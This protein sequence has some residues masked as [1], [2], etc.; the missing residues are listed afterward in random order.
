[1]RTF[2]AVLKKRATD[3]DGAG[4]IT[5]S[6]PATEYENTSNVAKLVKTVLYVT[7]MTEVEYQDAMAE[8]EA[9]AEVAD[10]EAGN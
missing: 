2:Q 10:D 7:V 6:F 1:M 3:D 5:F 8:K 9:E 4:Q